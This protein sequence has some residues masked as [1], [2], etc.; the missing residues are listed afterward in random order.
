MKDLEKHVPKDQLKD[1][2]AQKEQVSSMH[3]NISVV[4]WR[5]AHVEAKIKFVCLLDFSHR[6]LTP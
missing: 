6:Y 4:E 3:Q 1:A 5:K 2:K